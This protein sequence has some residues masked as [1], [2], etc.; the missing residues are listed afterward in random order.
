[1]GGHMIAQRNS[2][3]VSQITR[4]ALVLTISIGAAAAAR[5]QDATQ[6][7]RVA[8]IP[9]ALRLCSAQIPDAGAVRSCMIANEAKLS[10]PCRATFPKEA[11]ER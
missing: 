1:M 2:L 10:P 3:S 5:A 9:D 4:F 6:E 7:Q 8:C 11:A